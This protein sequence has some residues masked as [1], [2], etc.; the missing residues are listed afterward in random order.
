LGSQG[1]DGDSLTE[2]KSSEKLPKDARVR[3]LAGNKPNLGF[4][5]TILTFNYNASADEKWLFYCNDGTWINMQGIQGN[6][7]LNHKPKSF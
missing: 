1:D 7:H 3:H 6:L 4:S 5:E 2:E